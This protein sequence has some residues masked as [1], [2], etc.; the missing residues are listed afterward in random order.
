MKKSVYATKS[1]TI[2]TK[3]SMLFYS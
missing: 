3:L 1:I 2:V